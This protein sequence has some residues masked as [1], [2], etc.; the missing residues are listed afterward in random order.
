MIRSGEWGVPYLNG[1]IF[2]DKPPLFFWLIA[3]P[4]SIYG[5]VTPLIARLPSALS[6][7][8]A[9][10]LLFFWA[11]RVY[12]T[13]KAGLI[14]GGILLSCYQFFFQAR[15]AKTDLL[16]CLCIVLSLFFF[17]LGYEERGRRQYVFHG[18]CF[19]SIGLGILTKGPF[20]L[21]VPLLVM[22]IFLARERRW[23]TW[24]SKPFLLGY[25]ISAFSVMPWIFLFVHRVGL[26]ESIRL[27]KET[28]ILTREAPF[29]FYFIQIW[30]QFFPWSLLLPFLFLKLWRQRRELWH[31]RDFFFLIWFVVIF[32]ALSFFKYR[33]SRYLLPALPPLALMIGGV[34]KKRLYSFLIPFLLFVLIWH[35]V[36]ISW[37]RKDKDLSHSQGMA[38]AGELRPFTKESTLLG[39]QL[40]A[41]TQE[42]INFYLDRVIPQMGEKEDLLKQRVEKEGS[43]VLMSREVY[44]D[45]QKRG[46]YSMT[47]VKEFSYKKGRLILISLSK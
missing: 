9:V 13:N 2:I 39:F 14:S 31:S 22:A 45:L 40:D 27:V 18:L 43:L 47:P 29:Y 24:I 11:R 37:I 33:T 46:G 3:I 42:E 19:F 17:H 10:V 6:A 44:E 32:V 1:K 23:G 38:L 20:G 41:S 28:E 36:E 16:L 30:I 34:W 5:S 21:F 26:G 35:G 12:G 8:A 15:L 4:A 25:A 7:W